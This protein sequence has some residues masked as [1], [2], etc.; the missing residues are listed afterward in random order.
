MIDISIR[1]DNEYELQYLLECELC[2][3]VQTNKIKQIIELCWVHA[4]ALCRLGLLKL[5]KLPH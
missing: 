4:S 3:Y 2:E 5:L 1:N